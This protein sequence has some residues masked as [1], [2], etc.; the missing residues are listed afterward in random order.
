MC[1]EIITFMNL[2][3]IDLSAKQ[4]Y[5]EVIFINLGVYYSLSLKHKSLLK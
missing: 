4:E 5:Y 2:S 1:I 3:C